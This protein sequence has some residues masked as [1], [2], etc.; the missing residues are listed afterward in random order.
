MSSQ[1]TGESRNK[2]KA[3]LAGF[4]AS[5]WAR[6]F[7]LAALAF[8]T[9][10]ALLCGPKGWPFGEDGSFR[11]PYR[12][13]IDVYRTGAQVFLSGGDL[14]GK[15]PELASGA[16][17]LFTYPPI[18]AV[19]FVVFALMPLPVASMLLTLT[20]TAAL[21]VVL[22]LVLCTCGVSRRF[23]FWATVWGL[24]AALFLG[25]V[26]ATL[27]FGQINILLMT[28]VVVDVIFGRGRWW[29][30]SLVG[31]AI[32]IKLTPLVFLVFFALRRDWRAMA[33][34]LLS[35]AAA[36]LLGHLAMPAS[37]TEYWTQALYDTKRIGNPIYAANVSVNGMLH[38]LGLE[39]SAATLAWFLLASLMGLA[40]LWTAGRLL[41][42]GH[43]TVALLAVSFIALFASP[44]SWDH[45]WV[46][47]VP[48]LALL[49]VWAVRVPSQ[50]GLLLTWVAA[51]VFMFFQEYHMELPKGKTLELQWVWWQHLVG[52][53][54]L[55][56][57]LGTLA[58]W[59][60]LAPKVPAAGSEDPGRVL[61]P[62]LFRF[63][64]ETEPRLADVEA[65]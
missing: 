18:A 31:L 43:R 50:R 16:Q 34:S 6:I 21:G 38:R 13:D 19:L 46:W 56:W 39:G 62:G 41:A 29:G 52:S 57:G 14:Y 44:V 47:A 1:Q 65:R 30:G 60:L 63:R 26:S 17:L 8:G 24:A 5:P 2:L 7:S 25:P 42:W 54:Y 55:I 4:L 48:S 64:T 12:I 61:F 22:Y 49:V 53:L 51:G 33:M 28:L 23:A 37:S 20:S 59:A 27:V 3:R 11:L 36:T 40:A 15:L 32:A 58:I 9:M 35:A 10:F 45:H